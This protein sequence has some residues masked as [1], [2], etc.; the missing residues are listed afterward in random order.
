LDEGILELA[1]SEKN[2]ENSGEVKLSR[3]FNLEKYGGDDM[4]AS[5]TE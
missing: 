3:E 1:T 2:M 4:F 5:E